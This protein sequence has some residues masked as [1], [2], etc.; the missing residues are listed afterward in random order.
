MPAITRSRKWLAKKAR[1]GF[2]GFP[3]GTI[4]YYGP[5]DERASKIAV[6]IVMADD[7]DV[8]FMERW[9]TDTTDARTD[10]VIADEM[11][12]FLRGHNARSIILTDRIIGCPHEEGID[13]PV[14][15]ACPRCPFWADRDRWEGAS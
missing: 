6:G 11:V 10:A 2:R 5:D 12:V 3:I 8:E 4:A 14:G 9:T 15:E 13:Y 7:E 1:L